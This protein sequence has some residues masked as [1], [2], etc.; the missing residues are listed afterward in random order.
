M[1]HSPEGKKSKLPDTVPDCDRIGLWRV[2]LELLA[3][4][5]KTLGLRDR[6]KEIC[7]PVFSSQG[8]C[9]RFTLNEESVFAE[10]SLNAAK[11][12]PTTLYELAH[13]TVH[14]LNPITG[15]ANYLEEGVAVAF[16]LH[17]QPTY[18]ICQPVRGEAYR[19]A[20]A[21]VSRLP[22]G[23][24]VAGKFVRNQLGALSSATTLNLSAM[25]ENAD[26]DLLSQLT[27][28]FSSEKRVDS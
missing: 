5:E 18:Q 16:S 19:R 12:W 20:H 28:E 27:T 7:R 15:N 9:I 8:P 14:L 23:A 3:I 10:L 25:F 11:Y 24:L 21:L 13:E 1:E 22:G 26:I 2:Q 17:V 4:A 6:S